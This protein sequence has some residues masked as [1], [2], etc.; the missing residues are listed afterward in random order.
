LVTQFKSIGEAFKNTASKFPNKTALIYLGEKYCYSKLNEFSNQVAQALYNMGVGKGDRVIIYASHCPQWVITWLAVQKLGAVAVPVTHFYGLRDLMYIANDSGAETIFCMDTNYGYV[1]KMLADTKIK[2]VIVTGAADLL[3]GWKKLVGNILDKIPS[4][5]FNLDANIF[6]FN[7]LLKTKNGQLP[8]I[9]FSGDEL[10]E[11]LYTGGTTGFSKGVPISNA[12]LLDS[13]LGQRKVTQGAIPIGEDIVFLGSPLYHILGQAVGFGC[14]LAGETLIMLPKISLDGILDHIERYKVKSVAGTPNMYRMI[15]EHDRVDHYCLSSLEYC[16]C[17]GDT[18]PRETANRWLKK[19]GTPLY[20]AYGATETCGGVALTPAGQDTP[21][22]T[23]GKIVPWQ[24]VLVVDAETL[25]P[26]PANEPGELLVSSPHMISGYWNKPE[27]TSLHFL[28]LQGKLWYR[29]GDIVKLDEGN[30]LYF[31]DRSGDIIKHKGYRVAASKVDNVLQE[32]TA[33]MAS[34]TI[35]VPDSA[36][37][38]RIKS[39]V[40]IKDDIKGVDARELLKWCRERL[41]PYEVP[42]Y[43]EFRD[44]LPKSKVGKI[45]KRELKAEEHRKVEISS[46]KSE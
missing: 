43:I 42:Q 8:E 29:T 33:V 30:W 20:E 17:G 6:L 27:E 25:E 35:G 15:L 9:E 3:P 5:K 1:D 12:M 16:M 24:Q 28:Q 41:A 4:G 38:E 13:L 19:F 18:V 36:V 34:S 39:Y 44:M 31:I 46:T 7:S 23:A 22:G 26:V 11:T 37:G 14:L 10:A 21:V 45:L 40:V 2:R 32:H